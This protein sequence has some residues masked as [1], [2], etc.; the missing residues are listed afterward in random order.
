VIEILLAMAVM[1]GA[2]GV[3][4]YILRFIGAARSDRAET[5]VFCFALGLGSLILLVLFLGLVGALYRSVIWAVVGLW[6]LA[7]WRMLWLQGATYAG[8]LR[9]MPVDWRSPYLWLGFLA[10]IGIMLQLVRALTPPHG[11]TDPLAYQLALPRLYLFAHRLSFEPTITGAL[12][13]ANVGLLYVVALALR[14]GILAQLFHLCLSG[15]VSAGIFAVGRRYL[16]WQSGLYGAVIFSFIPAVVF[17]GPQG[18]VDVGLCFFQFTALWAIANWAR[19]PE[20][21]AL[22]LAAILSGLAAGVKPQGLSTIFV[23]ILVIALRRLLVDRELRP[24]ILDVIFYGGILLMVLCPWFARSYAYSGNPL[25]PL[26][27]ELFGG[28]PFG[29]RTVVASGDVFGVASDSTLAKLWRAFIPTSSWFHAYSRSMNPWYWTFEPPGW[30]KAIGIY[31]IALLPGAL[32]CLRRRVVLHLVLFCMGYYVILVRLLHM[33][34]RYGL[35]LFAVGSL[36][37]GLAA[38][39][40]SSASWRPI[41]VLFFSGFLLS[42]LLNVMWNYALARPFFAVAMGSETRDVFLSRAEGNYRLF[43]FVN[44]N[45][46]TDSRI[47]LQGIV[48]GFYCEREYLWDHPH[49]AVLRYE[50]AADSGQLLAEF[51]RLGIT[52]VARMIKIPGGRVAMGY[53]QYFTDE[54]HEDFRRRHLKLL[55]QDESFVL[56][57]VAYSGAAAPGGAV[58]GDS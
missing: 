32:L 29:H 56:F 50:S 43:R 42:I 2:V 8:V 27:N 38:H 25:W 10:I 15:A 18:Y 13:P 34:P 6:C 28:L 51:R 24:A 39:R 48:R 46:A 17:Y 3:G 5:A 55:Y 58:G 19:A 45:T 44:Q 41:R 33:N 40:L 26:A 30:Q 4:Q 20:R 52:H 16:S 9:R 7:G 36:L 31:F 37:C 22:L 47:L 54:Y 12:Y 11:T 1:G 57:E 35:V 14:N 53:P 49:Q 21:R 23:G